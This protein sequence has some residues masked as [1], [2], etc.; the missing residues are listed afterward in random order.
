MER[1]L[2]FGATSAIAAEVCERHA[3]RGDRLH[4]VGRDPGRL[5]AVV[6]RCRAAGA[7]VSFEAADLD[8][9]D[10]AAALVARAVAAL[11]GVDRALVA[12]GLLGDQ[13]HTERV[14]AAAEQV[15]RTNLL[16]AV[17]VLVPLCDALER[18][19]RLAVITSVAGDRG[20]P[21]NYTYGAAKGALNV[22]MQG[23]RTRLYPTAVSVTTIKLGPVDT[24]MTRD[25]TKN[26]FFA[27]P[28]GVARRI[29][30]AMDARAGEIYIPGWWRLIMPVVRGLPEA[31]LQRLTFLSGR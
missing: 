25:H 21:R 11:G 13:Q 2:V 5:A 28:V 9:T 27:E 26:V 10:H 24:P 17:S 1:V 19:A 30:T 20:R 6:G 12:H 4:L 14:Y 16:S 31:V 3:R 7:E 18:G 22:Y 29:V 8:E 23:V 15:F